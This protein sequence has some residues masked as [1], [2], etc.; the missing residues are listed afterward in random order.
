M[1][2]AVLGIGIVGVLAGHW[3]D[4]LRKTTVLLYDLEDSIETAYQRL[5][6]AA[7]GLASCRGVWHIAAS[8]QVRDKK[9]HAG[10]DTLV[11]RKPTSISF[12]SPPFM[13]TNIDTIA[14]EVGRQTVHFFPD[15]ILVHAPNGVGAVAYTALALEV[16]VSRFIEDQGVP[17]DAQVVDYTWRYVNKRGGPDRRFKDNPRLPICAYQ[18]ISLRSATGLN[19]LIQLS[20]T[21]VAEEFAQAVEHLASC[22]QA[23]E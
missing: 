18:S 19:E 23:I 3:A 4:Q 7:T 8:G 17:S 16:A 10:A 21:D 12:S 6:T 15:R 14:I 1:L 5:H 13:K 20:R 11:D 22:V 9:Y 2:V